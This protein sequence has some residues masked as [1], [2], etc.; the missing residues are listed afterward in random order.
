[1]P[2]EIAAWRIDSG[3]QPLVF[4]PLSLESRLQDILDDDISIADPNLMVVGREVKTAFEKKIDILAM[5]RDGHLVVLELKRD[6]TPRDIIAQVL[7]YGSWVRELDDD[8]IA[9][10]FDMY[11][12][13]HHPEL[14]NRSIDQAFCERF[15]VRAM[16]DELNAAH[17]LIIVASH[18]DSATERIVGYL[19]DEYG[20]SVNA[21]FFR[22]F[23]DGQREYLTR[24]WL[25][26]PGF[27]EAGGVD[28]VVG[29]KTKAKGEWNGEYYVSFG[30]GSSRRWEDAV[31]YGFIS[32]G[33]GPF[34]IK[35]LQLLNPGDRVWVNVP[36]GTGYVGVGLVKAPACRVD[37][38]MVPGPNGA[39][40][41]ITQAT[42]EA[43]DMFHHANDDEKAEWF[44]RVDWIKTVPI[45]E[46]IKEKGFFGN[47]NTVAAPRVPK[48]DHT[49][50]RLTQRFDLRDSS[51]I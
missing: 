29:K 21:V 28:A 35:T 51:G 2:L 44:V 34:Y 22:C 10:I 13:K 9:T 12:T 46:A 20:V 3:V 42:V 40:T 8:D 43:P 1:M 27:A 41:P 50:Q 38:F 30:V 23:K 15:G 18:L 48:W 25:R 36:G 33:G 32:G 37:Q 49:V 5:N 6:K 14:S 39:E 4:V 19:A 11:Q 26:E 24:A 31:R 47:Q 17:E 45:E 16:P 7:D